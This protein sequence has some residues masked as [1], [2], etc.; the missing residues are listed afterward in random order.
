[1]QHLLHEEKT[2]KNISLSENER[3][4]NEFENCT[5]INCDL[6]DMVLSQ[7]RFTDC[8]F[9]GCNLGMIRFKQCQL[10]N[11]SFK[12]CKLL[13][14]NFSECNDFLFNAE[15]DGCVM[16]YCSFAG[17]K[18]PKTRFNSCSMKSADLTETD[19]SRSVFS[20]TDLLN[21]V[22]MNTILKEADMVTAYNYIIDP[23]QNQLKKAK[24]SLQAVSGLLN[25]Y[26][27]KIQ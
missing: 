17:K 25:K 15:F 7:C 26:D 8:V 14:I 11:V 21:A 24:F 22:F 10:N 3:S 12:D 27:I 9:T 4:D 2:F 19:L 1:M 23:E 13:G 5:F 20:N 18:I 6:S 16:D